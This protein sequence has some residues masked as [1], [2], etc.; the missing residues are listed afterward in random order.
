[1]IA[2]LWLAA[3]AHAVDLDSLVEAWRVTDPGTGE[4]A[5]TAAHFDDDG[6]LVV[7]GW[8]DD[9]AGSIAVLHTYDVDGTEVWS[10]TTDPGPTKSSDNQWNDVAIDPTTGNLALCG[11]RGG[12]Q[13]ALDW[14]VEVVEPGLDKP[15]WTVPYGGSAQSDEQWCS[16]IVWGDSL[17]TAGYTFGDDALL[18]QWLLWQLDPDTGLIESPRSEDF[19]A[20]AG[21]V[22]AADDISL[23]PDGST[24]V[25]GRIGVS[26]KSGAVEHGILQRRTDATVNWETLPRDD[27]DPFAAVQVDPTTSRAL[28]VATGS[29]D[30]GARA[31]WIGS[32]NQE[33]GSPQSPVWEQWWADGTGATAIAVDAGEAVVAGWTDAGAWTLSRHQAS[34]GKPLGEIDLPGLSDGGS[35]PVATPA[36][37]A[38][39]DDLVAVVGTIDDGSGPSFG[40]VFLGIDS[41][42]DGAA[43][44]VDGCPDDTGKTDP[45]VCGCDVPDVDSDGDGALN[46]EEECGSDPDKLDPGI[47]GCDV[48]DDDSDGDGTADCDDFCEDDPT[49]TSG[50]VCGCGV[51][52]SDDDGDGLLVCQD[53]CP[54]TPPGV[55]V[56][57]V[58]CALD[59]DTTVDTGDTGGGGEPPELSKGCGCGNAAAPASA[60]GFLALIALGVARRRERVA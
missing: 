42:E 58:G 36:A 4:G 50:G 17:Y 56:D 13:S 25:A 29:P 11:Q 14:V 19:G 54:D 20:F 16:A 52:D 44:V 12:N 51:P 38:I 32:Y 41:D 43:D 3:T 46:C 8:V 10:Y 45:G 9:G 49:K 26:T 7:S 60:A 30:P 37:V 28:A 23:F 24:A 59:D 22:D 27:L 55:P 6:H 15:L 31:G 5:A 2:A 48:P 21:T 40:V 53:Q 47:C 39:R 18:G 57:A 1:M 33:S 35:S 34:S